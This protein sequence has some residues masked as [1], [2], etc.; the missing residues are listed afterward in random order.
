[1]TRYFVDWMTIFLVYCLMKEET[2]QLQHISE[3]LQKVLD[4]MEDITDLFETL[5][6]QKENIANQDFLKD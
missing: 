5:R 2:M 1:M 3:R 6:I 4:E